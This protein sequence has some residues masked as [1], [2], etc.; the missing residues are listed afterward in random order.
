MEPSPERRDEILRAQARGGCWH[1]RAG[2][3]IEGYTSGTRLC[4]L[5]SAC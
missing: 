4:V 1:W 3:R 5:A 2:V